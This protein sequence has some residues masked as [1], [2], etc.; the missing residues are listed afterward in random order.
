MYQ[1]FRD[2]ITLT[3]FLCIKRAC[4]LQFVCALLEVLF[5]EATCVSVFSNRTV[6]PVY[7]QDR[8]RSCSSAKVPHYCRAVFK[9]G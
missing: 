7:M 9:V 3:V 5:G 1:V 6:K 8:R 4:I 2:I